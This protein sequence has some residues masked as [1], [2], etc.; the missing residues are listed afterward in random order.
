MEEGIQGDHWNVAVADSPDEVE[1][2]TFRGNL[3]VDS[4]HDSAGH[5]WHLRGVPPGENPAHL[6]PSDQGS[7][8]VN[9]TTNQEEE[10]HKTKQG[11]KLASANGFVT[12]NTLPRRA[13]GEDQWPHQYFDHLPASFIKSRN[14]NPSPG[15]KKQ[16]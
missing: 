11:T 3:V 8:V 4:L 16:N 7:T 9:F 1:H 12:S 6:K 2:W 15:K 10:E 5:A 13:H 14:H